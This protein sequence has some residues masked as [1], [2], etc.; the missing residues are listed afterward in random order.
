MGDPLPFH[1]KENHVGRSSE[2]D[3]GR[4]TERKNRSATLQVVL[5]EAIGPVH[6]PEPPS[7]SLLMGALHEAKQ[8]VGKV[9]GFLRVCASVCFIGQSLLHRTGLFH[10]SRICYTSVFLFCLAY[11]PTR[12]KEVSSG[13]PDLQLEHNTFAQPCR[14]LT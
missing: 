7:W 10:Q 4:R 14:P 6:Y 8:F 13:G 11:S 3:G 1:R 5:P 2:G 9:M 12:E